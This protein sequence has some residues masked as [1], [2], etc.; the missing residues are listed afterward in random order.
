M[1]IDKLRGI[2]NYTSWKFMMKMIL[3]HEDLWDCVADDK[4]DVKK[5]QKAQAKIA[6]TVSPAAIPHIRNAKTAKEA[7]DNLQ[8][9]YEDK[10]LCRRLGLLRSL[11]GTKLSESENMERYVNKITEI[12]QQLTEIGSPLE[13]DFVAVLMLSG[14]TADYDPFI[15]AIENTSTKLSSEFVKGKLLQENLRRDDK[16]ESATALI[17]KK[18][19][20]CFKC[21]QTGHFIKN[22]PKF[23]KKKTGQPEKTDGSKA[24]LL[25]LSAN[26]S[27]GSWY[28]DSGATGHMCRDS[29]IMCDFT[30]KGQLEVST[31][32]GEKLYTAGQGSVRVQMKNN[33]VKTISDVHYVPNLT[34]NLLSVSA[35][36]KKGYKVVFCSNGC[37]VYDNNIVV[38]T[39]TLCNGV[40]QL[41]TVESISC[42][43]VGNVFSEVSEL[44]SLRDDAAKPGMQFESSSEPACVMM[45]SQRTEAATQDVWHRRL[46]HLNYKS[47]ELLKQGMAAGISYDNKTYQKCIACIEGKQTRL[48]F[49]KRTFHRATEVLQLVH[50]DVCGPMPCMSMSGLKYFLTFIDDFSRKTFV[51]FLKQ[52]S[53]VFEKFKEWKALVENQTN[54]KLKVI[55]SDNG[56]EFVNLSFQNFMKQNGIRHETTVPHSPQQNG[57]AERANRSIMEKTRCMLREAGLEKKYWAEAVNTAVYLKNRSP[58]IAVRGYTPEEKWIK[59]KVTISHLR[60]FGCIA[61]AH[62]QNRTKLDPKAKP[63]IFVGYC[64]ETK[65]YRLINPDDPAECIKA[66]NVT[67]LENKFIKNLVSHDDNQNDEVTSPHIGDVNDDCHPPA[68]TESSTQESSDDTNV[69]KRSRIFNQGAQQLLSPIVAD[70]SESDGES[71]DT[72]DAADETYVPDG[73][74]EGETSC[75]TSEFEDSESFPGMSAC[76]VS[77]EHGNAA[78]PQTV[79]EALSSPEADEWKKAMEDEYKSFITNKCWSLCDRVK[80]QKPVKC[81][82][83]FKRKMINGVTL[84]YKARLV[85][86]GFTQKQGIDYNETFSPVVRYSSIRALLAVAAEYGMDIDHLDV[87]T[88]FL[89]GDLKETVYMEQPEAFNVKGEENKV[90]KLHKAIYGLKQASKAWYEKINNVLCEKLMFNKCSSE[91]CVYHKMNNG[92]LMIIALYVDDILLFSM[93]HSKNKYEIKEKLKNEFEITDLGPARYILGMQ[94]CKHKDM[95]TLDQSDY[96]DRILQK[97][98]MQDCKPCATPMETGVTLIKSTE[99]QGYISK[100][101]YRGLIGSLMYIAIGSRPDIAHAVSYLSQFNDNHSEIHWKSA[102]RILRYLKGTKSCCLTFQKG[103][104]E[105][106]AF[107]DSDWGRNELDRRSYTGFVFRLGKSIVSWESRKQKTV[108]LSST[109]AEYMS[110]TDTCKEALFLRKFMKEILN[111]TLR[112]VIYNDNQS[113]Q[114]LCKNSMFHARTKHIDI[115]HHFIR[116]NVSNGTIDVQYLCTN[117]MVADLL[118]KPLCKEKHD[119]FLYQLLLKR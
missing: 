31:A 48:P 7:W 109:E 59:E 64:Q 111:K 19:P 6:L 39:A 8:K 15:M 103:G 9:A 10:G 57:V 81:K 42:N 108:A 18:Q 110:L 72:N 97:Y 22:C 83:V 40:Y 101:D 41:D 90:Y 1:G 86:K 20:R 36:V 17:A 28:I 55:R 79:H 12:S 62:K 66:R 26:I 71:F 44:S 32:N 95:I 25:A 75:D 61:Y 80:S 29:S 37:K 13:D 85:A 114:K 11:F 93:P 33:N 4:V 87:K 117:D 43:L 106:A 65:G 82:W 77:E 105:I 38:A 14:L 94:I 73:S 88:A 58:T 56:G 52:K 78:E 74:Q 70:D 2:D 46:G 49:P 118:T 91:P 21:K 69:N 116:E 63:Y 115:R 34:T 107:A 112:V 113:A 89:N 104:L 92:S 84:K 51:Y 102:K 30:S 23:S 35:M 5:N 98:K 16:A 54:K 45:A 67:F 24:L 53:E 119:K 50:S 68:L 3:I 76:L 27:S 47:M 99:S 60:T 96:I 100:Y